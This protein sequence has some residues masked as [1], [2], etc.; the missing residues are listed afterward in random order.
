ML[1]GDKGRVQ[2]EPICEFVRLLRGSFLPHAAC[3]HV[4]P[5]ALR[6]SS[7]HLPGD[8][9]LSWLCSEPGHSASSPAAFLSPSPRSGPGFSFLRIQIKQTESLSQ[10]SCHLQGAPENPPLRQTSPLFVPSQPFVL[11]QCHVA[12]LEC[13]SPVS[14]PV[15]LN[16]G[17]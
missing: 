12:I 10:I 5:S 11:A 2:E 8:E 15:F 6:R 3:P 17:S 7:P 14:L 1:S 13:H 9:V 4:S 16:S